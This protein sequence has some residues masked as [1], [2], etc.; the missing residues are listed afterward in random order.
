LRRRSE[1]ELNFSEIP[2]GQSD[3]ASGG[4]VAVLGDMHKNGAAARKD[5]RPMIEIDHAE[6]VI[7][8]ILAPKRFRAEAEGQA[9]GAVVAERAWVV[10]PA[11]CF[12]NRATIGSEDG[13]AI[14]P[15]HPLRDSKAA[16]RRYGITLAA[17]D[18]NPI[19]AK[20]AKKRLRANSD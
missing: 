9:D 20:R 13:P 4:A 11:I 18:A 6:D 19:P 16:D 17:F 3:A 15:P 7:K 5:A 14:G 2:G 10:A 8:P 1:T 12:G